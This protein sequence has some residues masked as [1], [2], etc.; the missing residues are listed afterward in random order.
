MPPRFNHA[1]RCVATIM[2]MLRIVLS[3]LVGERSRDAAIREPREETD[4]SAILRG[5]L[6]RKTRMRFLGVPIWILAVLFSGAGCVRHFTAQPSVPAKPLTFI[7][8]S[9]GQDHTCGLDNAGYAYCWGSNSDGQLGFGAADKLPHPKPSQVAGRIKFRSVSAG[10]RHTCALTDEGAA[11]CWGANDFGQLGDGSRTPSATAVAVTGKLVLAS[12]SAGAT[13]TCGV[14]TSGDTYCWGGNWHGQLGNGSMDGEQRY[15]CCHTRPTRVVGAA[16]S[17]VTAGGVHTCAL[18]K[19]G[20]AYCW[21][22]ANYGRLGVGDIQAADLPTPTAVAGSLEFLSINPGGFYTCALAKTKAAYCWGAG[23][24][25]QLSNGVSVAEQNVPL[26]VS[27]TLRFTVIVAGSNHTCSITTDGSVYCWGANRFGQIGD[28]ST[29]TRYAP[30]AVSPQRK[31][32]SISA[33]GND[34]SGHTCGITT[35]NK[36]L[37]WGDNRLG[38]LGN[39]STTASAI[40]MLVVNEGK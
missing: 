33:G 2:S 5:E 6:W 35:D 32:K 25:G 30:T 7:L 29:E 28:G 19:T 26:E 3:K 37:C 4:L 9:A 38:Q 34:F 13:H 23:T 16:F 39:G 1:A 20:R 11:Y 31:F 10:S 21:G 27:G 12:L 15:A 22:I 17:Q 14:T 18:T 24:D 36:T 40:P 8:V